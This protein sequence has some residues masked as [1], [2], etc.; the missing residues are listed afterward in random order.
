MMAR[1]S[2]L[3]ARADFQFGKR[4]GLPARAFADIRSA[5]LGLR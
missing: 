4:E 1:D 3:R 2:L 5:P